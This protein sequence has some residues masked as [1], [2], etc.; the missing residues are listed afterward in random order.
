VGA[1]TVG[2]RELPAGLLQRARLVVDDREQ[3]LQ[4]GELQWAREAPCVELGAL[5][6]GEAPFSRGAGDI[7][8]FDMT[9]LALQDLTVARLIYERASAQS[10]GSRIGWPW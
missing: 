1:D 3:A 2:K 10:L 6:L 5:L 8:V 9:G 7:T 4:L